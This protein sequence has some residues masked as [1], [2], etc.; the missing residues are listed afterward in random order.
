MLAGA[1]APAAPRR[2]ILQA[3]SFCFHNTFSFPEQGP[4]PKQAPPTISSS[5]YFV[6]LYPGTRSSASI[7]S[8]CCSSLCNF[9]SPFSHGNKS[10]KNLGFG[11]S[12]LPNFFLPCLHSHHPFGAV[13]AELCCWESSAVGSFGGRGIW[14][15]EGLNLHL[16]CTASTSRNGE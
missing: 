15:E 1:E 16:G 9:F 7:P 3:S 11:L 8:R 13:R 2:S 12:F 5:I 6:L 4:A 14:A 10:P